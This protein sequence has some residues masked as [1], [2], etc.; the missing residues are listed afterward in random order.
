MNYRHLYHAGNF[1]DVVKHTVLITLIQAL[2]RK[3]TPFCFLDTHAGIGLYE[4]QSE[5]SQKT[6][7]YVTGAAKLFSEDSNL[8][9]P[10]IQK[11]IS[12]IKKYNA[13]NNLEIYPGSPLI[14]DALLRECDRMILSELHPDDCHTL[15]NHFSK[16]S[17]VAIHHTDAYLGMKAFLPPKEKRGLVL[18]DPAFEVL[19]E[20]EQIFTALQRALKHWRSGHFMIWYPIKDERKIHDFYSDIKKLD[21]ENFAIHFSLDS[22]SESEKLSKCGLLLLNPPWQV[23]ENLENSILPYLGNHLAATWTILSV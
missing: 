20:C 7:E 23:K 1:A 10:E 16:G 5:Q 17:S 12:I 14:A 6:Q 19:N 18:I 4:L 2:Q 22:I 13:E 8:M 11:Y 15:K 21:V 9:P 3:E